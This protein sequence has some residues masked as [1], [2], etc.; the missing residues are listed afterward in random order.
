MR[1]RRPTD[2]CAGWRTACRCC[3][4]RRRMRCRKTR[5][6]AIASRAAWIIPTGTAF[7]WHWTCSARGCRPSS[8]NCS[9]P[10]SAMP[11]RMRWRCTGGRCPTAAMWKRWPRPDS[12][13]RAAPMVRCAS[14]PS[15]AACARCRMRRVRGST[16]CCRPCSMPAPGRRN[17]MRHCGASCRC[18]RRSCAAPATWRCWTNNPVR[19]AGWSTCWRVVRCCPSGWR[20]IPCCWTNCWTP[21]SPARCRTATSCASNARRR[22]WKTTR[23]PACGY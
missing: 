9:R 7:A 20:S 5:W 3:A 8:P 2:S 22:W 23:K 1:W 21:A 17:R 13:M 10:A 4:T 6:T 16:A 19:W 12:P 11:R 18:C 14:S 15:S